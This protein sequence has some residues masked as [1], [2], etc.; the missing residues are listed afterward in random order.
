M[1]GV[2]HLVERKDFNIITV[3]FHDRERTGNHFND[4]FRFSMGALSTF[5]FSFAIIQLTNELGELGSVF[6]CA[7]TADSASLISY[8]PF[9][10]WADTSEWQYSLPSEESATMIAVG[11]MSEP[12]SIARL[13]IAGTGTIVVA[14]D[15]GFLRFLT[16][17]GIQKYVWNLGEEV[18]SMAAGKDWVLVIY[19]SG[20]GLG[21]QLLDTDSFEIVQIGKIPTAKG[22]DLVWCGFT[23]EDVSISTSASSF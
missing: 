22:V 23:D 4:H 21:Y 20:N 13:S 19:E 2:I 1:L 8:K 10:S 12:S 18:I 5:Y 6:A 7:A 15:K 3:E 16:G 9:D 11:G 17:S 14:T